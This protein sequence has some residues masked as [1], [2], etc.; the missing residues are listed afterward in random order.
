MK[1]GRPF[2]SP[3]SQ[4]SQQGMVLL[5]ALVMLLLITMIGVSSMHNA[6]LQE[7]MASSVQTRNTTFQ[8][9]EAAL[10]AGENAVATTG[11]TLA[12]CT[13]TTTCA[14][15]PATDYNQVTTA[16][17]YG[18]AGIT[19]VAVGTTGFYGVQMIGTTS[20]PANSSSTS[21]SLYRITAIGFTAAT[22]LT[23]PRSVLESVYAK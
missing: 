11:Y 8:A 13:T 23:N 9:A 22:P 17:V 16:G 20:D 6:T 14:P 5:V 10:R 18:T 15:P 12:K 1:R 4:R 7:K 2:A 21:A 19:W 3:P